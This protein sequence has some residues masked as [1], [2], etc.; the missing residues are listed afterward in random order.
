[1]PDAHAQTPEQATKFD[2]WSHFTGR[3]DETYAGALSTPVQLVTK[4]T[5]AVLATYASLAEAFERM[6]E[7]PDGVRATACLGWASLKATHPEHR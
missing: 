4:A 7:I 3:L 5:G 1:M 2:R 6:H